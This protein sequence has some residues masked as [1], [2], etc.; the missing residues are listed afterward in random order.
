VIPNE[1]IFLLQT[2]VIALFTLF[3]LRLGSQALVS[4][5]CI[6]IVLANIFVLKQISLWGFDVMSADSFIIGAVLGFNLLHEY[7]GK[8]L[9]EKT[10]WITFFINFVV[11]VISYFQ[12]AFQPNI[13]DINHCHFQA[14]FGVMPRI[15]G[16]SVLAHLSSQYVRLAIY[17][18][19]KN[20]FLSVKL[21]FRGFIT[22]IIE[23]IIDTGA[24][25]FFA[26]YGIV[27][28]LFDVFIVSLITKIIIITTISP[29]I[30]LSKLFYKDNV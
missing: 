24:F 16:S 20:R 8:S 13:Y 6:L 3:A 14:I 26:L 9:A 17:S 27:Y 18:T 4:C 29:W 30:S 11:V 21:F 7:F 5:I 1:L 10:I 25:T 19:L 23:Q 28:S 15:V 22:T 12:L 2:S